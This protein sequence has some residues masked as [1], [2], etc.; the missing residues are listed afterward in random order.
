MLKLV[1][2]LERLPEETAVLKL[3]IGSSR[4]QTTE[5]IFVIQGAEPTL[6]NIGDIAP[7]LIDWDSAPEI[8]MTE[9]EELGWGTDHTHIRINAKLADGSHV[10]SLTLSTPLKSE[11]GVMT[12]GDQSQAILHLT[13][14][15]LAMSREVRNTLA[16]VTDSLAHRESVFGDVMTEFLE[17]KRDQ[18]EAEAGQMGMHMAMENLN[19]DSNGEFKQEMMS[20]L[21]GIVKTIMSG[22]MQGTP[23]IDQMK[24][25]ASSNPAFW[26]DLFSD[27]EITAEFIKQWT[28]HQ[29]NAPEE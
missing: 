2:F 6:K 9:A 28:I 25:W 27:Q 29:A 16:I 1:R 8:I 22:K 14:G 13:N 18:A 21:G 19:N 24:N 5:S 11:E 7:E 17:A 15:L 12:N 10:K 23:T 26:T 3:L 20:Q 4:K